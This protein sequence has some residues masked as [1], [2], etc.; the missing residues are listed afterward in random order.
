MFD[1]ALLLG[2]VAFRDFEIPSGINFGGAQRLAVHR[3]AGGARV[4]DAVGRDDA[5]ITFSGT[6]SGSDATLRAR[7]LDELRAAGGTL[8]LT[9]DVFFYT[10]V[11]SDFHADYQ[12][13]SWIPYR[14]TCTVLRDEASAV[15]GTAV[16]LAAD[17]LSDI[18]TAFGL[19]AGAGIDLTQVQAAL[20]APGATLRDTGAYV[21][22]QSAV[23]GGRASLGQALAAAE[24]ALTTAGSF[25]AGSAGAG[26]S[27]L[28]A[29][30]AASGQ[31]AAVTAAQ[32]YMGRTAV[33]LANAGT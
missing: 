5:N 12:S 7:L 8:P 14:L 26:A 33:N 6:F 13:V 28:T 20:S 4:I 21:S 30:T 16:S 18:G 27:N 32:G 22:A 15:I 17:A 25:A 9:W 1:I 10:V 24:G 19:A 31:L 23:A 11:I 29:M 2:P 3:L